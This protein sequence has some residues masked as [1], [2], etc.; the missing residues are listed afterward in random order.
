MNRNLAF[1]ILAVIIA[2]L[3]GFAG[4]YYASYKTP[5]PTTSQETPAP[6]PS[7]NPPIEQP[8]TPSTP[9]T[10]T[11]KVFFSKHSE[12]DDDPSKVFALNRTTSSI[13][14]GK[15][16][17]SELLKGPTA[18]EQSQGYFSYVR[19][20]SGDST[21]GGD[22]ISLNITSGGV[23]TLKFCKPF[24]HIG[25]ISDGQAESEIN[26]TLQQFSSVKK[27]IILNYKDDCEFNLSGLNLCK[28]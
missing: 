15:F 11:V 9:K 20:R 12:S 5:V 4:Y 14:V 24:D 21:C 6:Q 13:G 27:I 3:A 7:T 22:S 10:Y 26:A 2:C 1:I 25:S 28:Q 18:T 23:A 8:S 17:I 16:A 19:L